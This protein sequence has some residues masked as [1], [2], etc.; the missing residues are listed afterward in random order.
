MPKQFSSLNGHDV[1][2][3]GLL[4]SQAPLTHSLTPPEASSQAQAR[5][6]GVIHT[7]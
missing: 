4:P 1:E 5:L 7:F 6:F 2:S 3:A